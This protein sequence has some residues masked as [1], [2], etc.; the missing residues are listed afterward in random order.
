MS[1]VGKAVNNELVV[2]YRSQ[3]PCEEW[4]NVCP[5]SLSSHEVVEPDSVRQPFIGLPPEAKAEV[6]ICGRVIQVV[7]D[8]AF[9]N[10]GHK[11][12]GR[13]GVFRFFTPEI[14]DLDKLLFQRNVCVRQNLLRHLSCY[15]L[16]SLIDDYVLVVDRHIVACSGTTSLSVV[17][18]CS[19]GCVLN[20]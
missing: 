19:L 2:G 16:S 15:V 9:V 7:G 18:H 5:H 3:F 6:G 11:L 13:D 17:R 14:W 10:S 4:V 1:E 8:L 12:C 20:P